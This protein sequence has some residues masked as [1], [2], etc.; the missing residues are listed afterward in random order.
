[1]DFISEHDRGSSGSFGVKRKELNT[2]SLRKKMVRVFNA[3]I[4]ARDEGKGCISCGVGPVDH[5]GHY[6]PTSTYPQPSMR[7]NE[8][9]VH[10][11][12]C[13]CNTFQ[14]GN[15]QGY[16]K[17]LIKRYGKDILISLDVTRSIRQA[18]WTGFEYRVMIKNYEQKLK[19][20]QSVTNSVNCS[21]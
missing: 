1:V 4:R 14:E 21:E 16:E 17:G 11:Q 3:Y 18:S 8:H 6:W 9:N 10:G 15:R 5:A 7:F 12:C 13:H 2:A 20:F 19:E